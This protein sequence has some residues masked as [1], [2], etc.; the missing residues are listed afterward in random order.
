MK[1][2]PNGEK[3]V[4]QY[5]ENMNL[6]AT[7]ISIAD[8]ARKTGF[9]KGCICQCMKGKKEKYNGFYWKYLN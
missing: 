5:D 3:A 6:V 4:A 2:Y 9:S 7:Y 1:G 8:A